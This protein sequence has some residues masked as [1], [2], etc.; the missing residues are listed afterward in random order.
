MNYNREKN[1]LSPRSHSAFLLE[2]PNWL[3]LGEL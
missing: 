2:K 3:H 1:K